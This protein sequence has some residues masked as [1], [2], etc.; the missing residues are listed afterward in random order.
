MHYLAQV[1]LWIGR[2][3]PWIVAA[4]S[5]LKKAFDLLW[6]KLIVAYFGSRIAIT[7]TLL[8]FTVLM[9][10]LSAELISTLGSYF[11]EILIN[12]IDMFDNAYM[13]FLLDYIDFKEVF[14][15]IFYFVGLWSA[16]F[17]SAKGIFFVNRAL[18]ALR[19]AHQSIK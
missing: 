8:G 17:V 9:L 2:L 1:I 3:L 15:C 16:Y 5:W 4:T 7:I 18:S 13:A 19:A 6:A 14:E 10:H 12:Q 11:S